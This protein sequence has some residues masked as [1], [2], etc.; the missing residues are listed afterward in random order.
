M[1][2]TQVVTKVAVFAPRK[3]AIFSAEFAANIPSSA[4][5]DIQVFTNRDNALAWLQ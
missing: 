5:L 4:V 2:T 1:K 3:M